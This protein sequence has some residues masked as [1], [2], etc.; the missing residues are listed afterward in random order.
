MPSGR[1]AAGAKRIQDFESNG[2]YHVVMNDPEG[3]EFC[4]Q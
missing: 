3:N 2:E 4:I 1:G